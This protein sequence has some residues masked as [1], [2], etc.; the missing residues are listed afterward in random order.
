M[1]REQLKTLT[2]QMYYILLC[3]IEEQYGYS[4]MQKI[5]DMTNG[6]VIVGAGTLYSLLSRFEKEKIIIQVKKID[7]KKIYK[8]TGKGYKILNDEYNRLN[9]LVSDGKKY[10]GGNING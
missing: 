7:R 4:I 5:S 6:R 3:L 8:L 2:E 1:A 10:F 9:K